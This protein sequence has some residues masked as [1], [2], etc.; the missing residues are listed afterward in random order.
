MPE[1]VIVGVLDSK[2]TSWSWLATDD[3]CNSGASLSRLTNDGKLMY[4]LPE[5]VTVPLFT[6]IP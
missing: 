4:V 6:Y 2:L 3:L 5:A 1:M